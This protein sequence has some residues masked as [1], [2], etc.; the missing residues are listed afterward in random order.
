MHLNIT[1][2]SL[3]QYACAVLAFMLFFSGEDFLSQ[4]EAMH[5]SASTYQHCTVVIVSVYLE[6]CLDHDR[7]LERSGPADS[8][9][10]VEVRTA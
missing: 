5:S 3:P 6:Y 4:L 2:Y 1:R 9:L 10:G 8:A 7:G